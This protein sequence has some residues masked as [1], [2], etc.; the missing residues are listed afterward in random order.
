MRPGARAR[1]T[2]NLGAD[3]A[4]DHGIRADSETVKDTN[5]LTRPAGNISD[6]DDAAA[7]RW[8]KATLE[9]ARLH[10]GAAPTAE[11]VD[12]IRARIFGESAPRRHHRSIAA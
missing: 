12:R 6:I 10:V 1:P 7:V 2:P 3:T 11:A 4:K 9:P 5:M 8:L